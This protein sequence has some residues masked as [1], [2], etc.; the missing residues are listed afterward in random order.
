METVFETTASYIAKRNA[1]ILRRDL[2]VSRDCSFCFV[3]VHRFSLEK[4]CDMIK[5]IYISEFIPRAQVVADMRWL[6]R[7][8]FLS[9]ETPIGTGLGSIL[10]YAEQ[11]APS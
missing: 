5:S 3:K 7:T 4:V 6:R 10:E 8:C 2:I 9:L 1:S 11:D